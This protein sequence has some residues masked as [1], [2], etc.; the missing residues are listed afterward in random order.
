MTVDKLIALVE[1]GFTKDDIMKLAE[2]ETAAPK[3][4]V[5]NS[6]TPK[7][8]PAK[9][10]LKTE[11]VKEIKPVEKIKPEDIKGDVDD[12]INAAIEKALKPFEEMYN[13]MAKMAV[14]PSLENVEPKGVEDIVDKFFKGE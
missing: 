5:T 4:D 12:A 14:M 3:F 6:E 8:E 10:T 2:R 9:E 11:P 7:T 1:A 13:N